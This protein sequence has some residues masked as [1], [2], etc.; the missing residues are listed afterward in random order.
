MRKSL[1]I[2][3]LLIAVFL[4]SVIVLGASTFQIASDSFLRSTERKT[5]VL[6]EL[7]FVIEHLSKNVALGAGDVAGVSGVGI[8][9]NNGAG[10]LSI[11]QLTVAGGVIGNRT[12][13]YRFNPANNQ[14]VF[15]SG[16]ANQVLTGRF[17][18]L[19]A[20]HVLN[21]NVGVGALGGVEIG[22]LALVFDP[23]TYNAAAPDERD[24]PL[25]TTVDTAG[26]Q[27]ILY[28]YPLA[29]SWN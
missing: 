29:H 20:P 17:I 21:V 11:D 7:T 13:T 8:R 15:S 25:V 16:G 10:T 3:E 27:D 24:N 4:L 23:A 2:T 9:W 26:N 28:F 19:A 12:V 18:M 1:T 6:N 22:N 5:Q 14:I